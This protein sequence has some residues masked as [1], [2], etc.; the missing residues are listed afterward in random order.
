MYSSISF[1]L[2]TSVMS[3]EEYFDS[4][5]IPF[6]ELKSAT[7]NFDDKNLLSQ[8]SSTNIYK[9]QLMQSS[10]EFINIVV[11]ISMRRH[12]ANNEI[13]M[14]KDL[15]HENVVP[16]FKICGT[17]DT[18]V[19]IN[20]HEV[21]ESLDKHLSNSST[22]S[23][24]Q[25]LHI[26]VGIA[27]ALCY[28][29]HDAEANHSVIHGNIKS[30]KILLDH[31]WE[32]KLHG[33][34][35]AV[36]AR[37]NHLYLTDIYNGSL[38]YMD[39]AFETTGGLTNKSDV[40]SFGVVL[41]EVLFGMVASFVPTPDHYDNWYFARMARASYEEKTLDDM[42]HFD[43]QEQMNLESFNI[44]SETA[45]FCLKEERSQRP[46]MNKVLQRLER[47][48]ELQYKH[49]QSL[50]LSNRLKVNILDHLRFRLSDIQLST[51]NFSD[52]YR[53][54]SGG[55]G[56]VYKSKPGSFDGI[57]SSTATKGESQAE[58]PEKRNTI[59][60]KRL[61]RR[62]DG[63]AEQGFL[64]E[65]ELLS[66]CKHP[67]IVSL[68]GFC[69][70][71]QEMILI[72]EYASNGSL[73]DYLGNSDK[74]T[75]LT[76]AQR[77]KICI[78]IA[79]GLEYLHKATEDKECMI[80]RDIKSANI[81][82]NDKWEAKIA[83]FGL[84][85][86]HPT[87]NQHSTLIS[88]N[89]GGTQVYLDPEYL[90]TGK[91][92]TQSDIYSFGVVLFEIMSG[93]LAYDKMYNTTGLPLMARQCV[94]DKTIE[95]L[96]DPQL[97]EAY[98]DNSGPNDGLNQDSLYTFSKI[99]S[100]CVAK[101]Q[102]ERPTI[103]FV[104]K[105]LEKSLNL[106]NYGND[107]LQISLEA[108]K[109]GTQNFNDY[110]CIGK[111][112]FWRL[113]GGEILFESS[114]VR[115]PIVAK[116][117][118]SDEG[119]SQ[120]MRELKIL[121]ECKH[122]NIVGLVG[123]CKE[124]GEKIIVC[125]HASNG[126]LDKHLDNP[127]LTW[128]KRLKI[129]LDVARGLEYLH[130]G[131]ITK[132]T[133]IL[134][135]DIKSSS[136]LLDVDW[137]AKLS[138]FEEFS[139]DMERKM[140]KH[141]DDDNAYGSLSYL[142]PRYKKWGFFDKW[143]DLYSL[144]VV[145]LEM[146][147]GRLTCVEEIEEFSLAKVDERIFEGIKEQIVPRSLDVYSAIELVEQL[148]L[149]LAYQGDYEIWRPKLP[150]DYEKLLYMSGVPIISGRFKDVY[151]MLCDG[152]LFQEGKLWFSLWSD[153]KRNVMISAKRF[154][155]I[156]HGSCKIRVVPKARSSHYIIKNGKFSMEIPC[157]QKLTPIQT[158]K[159]RSNRK[160]R[161]QVVAKMLDVSNLKVQIKIKPQLL[162]PGDNY[163]VH[164]VFKF[165]E[166]GNCLAKHM[167]VNLKYKRGS[168]NLH[169]DFATWREDGWMMIELGQILN[170]KEDTEFEVL[171]E[172]FSRS[173]CGSSVYIEGIEFRT[174]EN[175]YEQDGSKE[176]EKYQETR[177]YEEIKKPKEVQHSLVESKEIM[178]CPGNANEG[179]LLKE[180]QCEKI[181]LMLSEME[182]PYKSSKEKPFHL[183]YL[184]ESRFQGEIELSK[185]QVFCIK[186]KIESQTL[187]PAKDYMCY[188]VY[189]LSETCNGL[190]CP[191]R[192]RNVLQWKNKEVGLICFRP[193]SPWNSPDTIG[194]PKERD[195]GWMEVFVWKFNS[196]CELRSNH[197]PMYLKFITY[198]GTMS[199]LIVSS[200]EIRPM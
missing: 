77:I 126:T 9:G 128:M 61:F 161:F 69:N 66:K 185:R 32:P 98:G 155:Y 8:T 95:K 14:L 188:L 102:V 186:G 15:K 43:L 195:D 174:I 110:N 182:A 154:S 13:I 189:K 53:I 68:I 151:D 83:D 109:L 35:F 119:N 107:N 144:G 97:K 24:M 115:T 169:S 196:K 11:R 170:Y 70:E 135:R 47:A 42:I 124:M 137:R 113:Y 65:I 17:A 148:T 199:G 78:D 31:H 89:I 67:N 114:T 57:C 28:L 1:N 152:F 44:F 94:N 163:G 19:I 129:G 25:R 179:L 191:V 64:A 184:A 120:F 177:V 96:V 149:A 4:I 39:P 45:Y 130:T 85:K 63:Q 56:A 81:L 192:V 193:S 50:V 37:R 200:L 176:I 80:H 138:N 187:S 153:G 194:V 27:R 3:R 21:N 12:I 125:E 171:L 157:G 143:S 54:G 180:I 74:I 29:H 178:K 58:F 86:L 198:E 134:H 22:L 40:F 105:E 84:S 166:P 23:W 36:R 72:Y 112:R 38:L 6:E 101:A 139:Y 71:E 165:R 133:R 168:D 52:A 145:L 5:W 142:D 99:A 87:Y 20:K 26:C 7:N 49:D 116:R 122:K 136:I 48:L 147:L 121:F 104:I 158:R 146:M 172:S 34:G 167:Y 173:F 51:D 111:G 82:L 175:V 79:Y 141:I 41:F 123:Y 18:L 162:L 103:D 88:G 140:L 2:C 90:E 190:H 91:L 55:Y 160:S 62:V 106:Q 76:W 164:L 108:I 46:D 117:F 159:W 16:T 92:K 197:I 59:A 131:G 183:K 156:N 75:N 30:S 93:N 33:F 127:D 100:Q 118:A 60:I 10:R 181:C 150:M 73:E 132:D